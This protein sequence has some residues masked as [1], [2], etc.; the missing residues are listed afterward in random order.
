MTSTGRRSGRVTKCAVV[1]LVSLTLKLV[2]S[3]FGMLI[4]MTVNSWDDAPGG[5]F[6][7]LFAL[8]VGMIAGVLC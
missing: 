2:L 7:T 6:L 1:L 5:G 4:V 3:I 8:A